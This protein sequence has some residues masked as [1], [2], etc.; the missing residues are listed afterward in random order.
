VKDDDRTAEAQRYHHVPVFMYPLYLCILSL[1][2]WH[3]RQAKDVRIVGE[4]TFV[5]IWKKAGWEIID[6]DYHVHDVSI[7][8]SCLPVNQYTQNARTWHEI[9]VQCLD[10]SAFY[11]KSYPAT[12][13]VFRCPLSNTQNSALEDRVSSSILL[14]LP[15]STF[16][17]SA[18]TSIK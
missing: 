6:F 14:C 8:A 12:R 15:H 17:C 16:T 5:H 18:H 7:S 1:H 4:I 9:V 13:V 2:L 11:R 10:S 3:P